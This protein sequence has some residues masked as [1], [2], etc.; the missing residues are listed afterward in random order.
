MKILKVKIAEGCLESTN[1][2]DLLFDAALTENFV[3]S[4][5]KES[6]GKLVLREELAKPFFRVIVRGKFT[7]Q[8]SLTNKTARLILPEFSSGAEEFAY[9]NEL[10]AKYSC[11]SDD[12]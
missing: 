8:G 2:R 10:T 6:G 9:L 7:L 1:A 12:N 5:A 3:K 4:L 11:K